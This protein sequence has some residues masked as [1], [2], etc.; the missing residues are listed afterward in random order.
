ME[1]SADSPVLCMC[2]SFEGV[3]LLFACQGFPVAS[4]MDSIKDIMSKDH[5]SVLSKTCLF[6]TSMYI[7]CMM[8]E[9]P[10]V[11]S[12]LAALPG[13]NDLPLI[14]PSGYPPD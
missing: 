8:Y 14:S 10:I 11:Q 5:L 13:T 1:D 12:V 2:L 3:R 7:N 6:T 9:I 4:K